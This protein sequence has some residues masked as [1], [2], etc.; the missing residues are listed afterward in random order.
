MARKKNL[1]RLRE[2]KSTCPYCN[3]TPF[4]F[5]KGD[6]HWPDFHGGFTPERQDRFEQ[7]YIAICIFMNH[8]LNS[9]K[10]VK[11]DLKVAIPTNFL[12]AGVR[13]DNPSYTF[14]ALLF[15]PPLGEGMSY[16]ALEEIVQEIVNEVPI[17][18][19]AYH[20]GGKTPFD[21]PLP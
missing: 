20:V 10:W 2:R 11:Y 16:E 3:G 17:S 8:L 18:H 7:V 21:K 9:R 14:V 5:E 19:V 13:G 12:A 1:K 15:G 4:E 6:W